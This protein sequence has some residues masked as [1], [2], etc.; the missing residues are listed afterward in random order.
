ME[1]IPPFEAAEKRLEIQF[2][3][4]VDLLQFPSSF[5]QQ[6]LNFCSATI[7][8]SVRNQ[9]IHAYLLSESSLLVFKHHLI[10]IT[11]GLCPLINTAMALIEHFTPQ[12]V[13]ELSF[14][15]QSEQNPELQLSQFSEDAARLRSIFNKLKVS[16]NSVHYLHDLAP[17][18]PNALHWQ[19]S[20][21]PKQWQWRLSNQNL[22]KPR[23][24]QLLALEQLNQDYLIDDWLF[25]PV[26][27][28]ANGIARKN[29]SQDYFCLH[30]SPEPS[31]SILSLECSNATTLGML[32]NHLDQFSQLY[33]HT[34]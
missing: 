15:R 31:C 23:L 33:S 13:R 12:S 6:Q 7:L 9:Q 14:Q 1:L 5:W 30:L 17:A 32:K 16:V 2:D 20:P 21:L 3:T 18:S 11:C 27:Y 22:D 34:T 29:G 4:S 26:G 28:S 25:E 19:L 8:S 24:R 10:L